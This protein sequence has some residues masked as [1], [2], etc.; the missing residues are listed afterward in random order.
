[1]GDLQAG[2]ASACGKY[3]G[4][5][6]QSV[7]LL[8][9]G[10]VTYFRSSHGSLQ[11]K[12]KYTSSNVMLFVGRKLYHGLLSQ[13]RTSSPLSPGILVLQGYTSAWEQAEA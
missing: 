11:I 7:Q 5:L 9:F 10:V 1:M 13:S 2:F 4:L 12:R 8:Q 3:H 6:S